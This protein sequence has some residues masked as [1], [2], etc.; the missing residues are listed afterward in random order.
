MGIQ[1]K[2]QLELSFEGGL[3]LGRR[4]EWR[5]GRRVERKVNLRSL[6]RRSGGRVC[7]DPCAKVIDSSDVWRVECEVC[8]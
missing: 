1:G 6:V 5:Y 2:G 4:E 3:V 7:S 8:I